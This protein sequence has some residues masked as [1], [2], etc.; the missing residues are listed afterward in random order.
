MWVH[1][2]GSRGVQDSTKSRFQAYHSRTTG[3]ED[4]KGRVRASNRRYCCTTS[5]AVC[6]YCWEPT[7]AVHRWDV[8]ARRKHVIWDWQDL[9]SCQA[10]SD[11]DCPVVPTADC[12]H[13]WP[14]ESTCIISKSKEEAECTQSY[15]AA[16]DD[17]CSENQDNQ[18]ARSCQATSRAKLQAA[19]QVDLSGWRT[20]MLPNCC[21][22]MLA[23]VELAYIAPMFSHSWIGIMTSLDHD[24]SWCHWYPVWCRVSIN[25]VQ[26]CYHKNSIGS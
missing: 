11:A 9:L 10:G 8:A 26:G 24:C 13:C 12:H 19:L 4:D 21:H 7:T 15:A 6:P 2:T 1:G 16:Q 25:Q 17:N 23:V 3:L 18:K 20:G 14:T 5:A 22:C